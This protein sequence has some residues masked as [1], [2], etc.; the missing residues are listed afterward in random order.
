MPAKITKED[1]EK[2]VKEMNP[3][4]VLLTEYINTH[5]LITVRCK[6]C[7]MTWTLNA[8]S[9]LK[10][11][12][13]D[14]C[15][16]KKPIPGKTDLLTKRPEIAAEWNYYRNGQL[17]PEQCT[18]FSRKYVYWRCRLGHEWAT[19]ISNRTRQNSGCPICRGKMVLKGFN[20][21]SSRCPDILTQW[22]WDKNV[23][24]PDEFYYQSHSDA[25]WKCQL[26]HSWHTKI[27][28][29]TQM[30]QGCPECDKSGTS[31]PEQAI[32]YYLKKSFTSC[33]NNYTEL[34]IELDI[35]IPELKTAIEYDGLRYH[36]GTNRYKSDNNKDSVCKEHNIRLIR[37]RENGL[38]QT[39]SA[40][41]IWREEP[42]KLSSLNDSIHNIF[43][44]LGTPNIDVDVIKDCSK[45][46]N[47]YYTFLKE[48]NIQTTFPELAKEWHPTENG[49][50]TPEMVTKGFHGKIYWIC[51][52]YPEHIYSST[53]SN[54]LMGRACP[55]CGSRKVLRGFN[56][57]ASINRDVAK[58]WSPNNS[59]LP[60]E[61]FPNSHKNYLWVCPK[62]HEYY[63]SPANRVKGKGCPYCSNQKVLRGF[64]DLLTRYPEI[65]KE[66]D[67]S[68]NMVGPEEVGCA[69]EKK[70]FWICSKGHSYDMSVKNRVQGK[71]CRY[72]SHNAVISGENDLA[73]IRKDLM[74]QWN[75]EKNTLVDP[76]QTALKSNKKVSWKC[77]HCGY[78]WDAYIYHRTEHPYAQCPKCKYIIYND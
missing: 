8:G 74:Q 27:Y 48:N 67:Y 3:H 42:N 41:T 52:N 28:L 19:Y 71:G 13:C 10:Q 38:P 56:D 70:Y 44:I 16:G 7:N 55:Y 34:G 43:R 15:Y 49:S 57:L 68:K 53:I 51:K 30:G 35:Y 47:T 39:K 46:W 37:V 1:F 50:L 4:L 66:W 62:G 76:A 11:S 75:F 25:W 33:V 65:A 2:R 78:I 59:I 77:N 36:Q 63:A 72:C 24:K 23:K 22:D 31:F 9:L 14:Y 60:S 32:Y 18:E 29:R 54:R 45:I 20:D 5:E 21:L 58:S 61:V 17:R 40:L 26:G 69:T 73:H 12:R 6:K 64:N